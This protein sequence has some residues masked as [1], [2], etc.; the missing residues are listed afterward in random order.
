VSNLGLGEAD[1]C[2]RAHDT[3]ILRGLTAGTVVVAVVCVGAVGDERESVAVC[4]A[5]QEA[6]QLGLAVETAVGCVG[7]ERGIGQLRGLDLEQVESQR[8]CELAS[9]LALAVG[10]RVRG[11]EH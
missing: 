11:R 8:R 7:C 1:L 4:D 2:Q 6:E 10:V 3:Q 5:R 9:T